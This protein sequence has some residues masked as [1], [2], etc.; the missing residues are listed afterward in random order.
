MSYSQPGSQDNPLKTELKKLI[1][2]T[3]RKKTSVEAIPDDA[4]IIGME[5]CLGLDSLDVLELSVVLKKR[6][7]VKIMDSKDAMRVMKSINSLA[8]TVALLA[9]N[10]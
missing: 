10:D 7:N 5:S 4:P 2:E 6:Y 3:C 9:K 1:I 8:D